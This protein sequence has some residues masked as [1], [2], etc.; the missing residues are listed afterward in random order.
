MTSFEAGMWI[1]AALFTGSLVFAGIGAFFE[2]RKET[3]AQNAS[4]TL[5]AVLIGMAAI[6]AG[7]SLL[8]L[9]IN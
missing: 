4:F 3:E 1:A 6:S 7:K 5:A 9:I 8:G 2:E